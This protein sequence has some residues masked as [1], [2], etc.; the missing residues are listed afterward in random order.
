MLSLVSIFV[1]IMSSLNKSDSTPFHI[2]SCYDFLSSFK[3]D[4]ILFDSILSIYKFFFALLLNEFSLLHLY[5]V[6]FFNVK[7]EKPI[8][9]NLTL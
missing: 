3:G 2:Q 5:F 1:S 6:I 9:I 7:Y 4:D 8:R